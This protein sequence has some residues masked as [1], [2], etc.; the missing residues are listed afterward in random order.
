M[1][2]LIGLSII[3]TLLLGVLGLRMMAVDAR[4]DSIAQTSLDVLAA[5]A[6]A[7]QNATQRQQTAR[8]GAQLGQPLGISSALSTSDNLDAQGIRQILRE[9]IAALATT[10]HVAASPGPA[11]SENTRRQARELSQ[12]LEYLISTGTINSSDMAKLQM[13]MA[14]L[15]DADRRKTLSRL[16]KAMNTGE[17]DAIF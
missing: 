3:Q 15:P 10:R 9:E 13:K 11:P 6:Q 7:E 17:I 8:L 4:I 14:R 1:K 12:E 16:T 5:T 2:L